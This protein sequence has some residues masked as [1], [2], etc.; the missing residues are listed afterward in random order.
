VLAR[1]AYLAVTHA[2]ALLWLVPFTDREKDVEILALRHQLTVL[3]RQLGSQRPQLRPEDRAFLAALLK[4]LSRAT[5]RRLRLLVSPDTLLRWH[6]NLVT[7]RHARTSV[8]RGPGRPRTLTSI[9]RR[10]KSR[11]RRSRVAPTTKALRSWP[12]HWSRRS[13]RYPAICY[14]AGLENSDTASDLRLY[15]RGQLDD[16]AELNTFNFLLNVFNTNLNPFSSSGPASVSPRW[17]C[18]SA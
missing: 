15:L 11:R 17:N 4:P 12:H 2:F 9:L 16:H 3:Q 18:W 14:P 10:P 5:L 7:H 8:N 6:R 13:T 1:F